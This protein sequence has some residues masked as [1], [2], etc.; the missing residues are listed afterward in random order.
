M[1]GA[2]SHKSNLIGPFRSMFAM[3]RQRPDSISRRNAAMG[4]QSASVS[5]V[6]GARLSTSRIARDR[7][8]KRPGRGYHPRSPSSRRPICARARLARPRKH[9]VD[10]S[11]SL[12]LRHLDNLVV[13]QLAGG[14]F[15]AGHVGAFALRKRG[16]EQHVGLQII[17]EQVGVAMKPL[18]VFLSKFGEAG[19]SIFV[20]DR[21]GLVDKRLNLF[22]M[23][24]G[25]RR[26]RKRG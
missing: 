22:G 16:I 19:F 1:T 7:T 11:G 26:L 2:R 24:G 21:R 9:V 6:V 8:R 15:L 20:D 10:P 23:L 4:R 5:A 18:A 12:G 14:V 17:N 13:K 3:L 25:R